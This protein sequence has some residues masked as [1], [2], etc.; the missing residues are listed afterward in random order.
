MWFPL[1]TLRAQNKT[2]AINTNEMFHGEP[3]MIIKSVVFCLRWKSVSR[4]HN[5]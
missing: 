4:L 3:R 1:N 5:K 2:I